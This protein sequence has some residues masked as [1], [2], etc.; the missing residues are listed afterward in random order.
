MALETLEKL[1][2]AIDAA[3]HQNGPQ[4]KTNASS[5]NAL[6]KLLANQLSETQNLAGQESWD[7]TAVEIDVLQRRFTVTLPTN[8]TTDEIEYTLDGGLTIQHSPRAL[9]SNATYVYSTYSITST[10]GLSTIIL[11]LQLGS[12]TYLAGQVGFRIRPIRGAAAGPW[13]FNNSDFLAPIVAS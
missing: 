13:L 12:S 6:L 10:Y 9:E 7:F 3:V 5:L 4:G 8:F 11:T 1:Y 2:V